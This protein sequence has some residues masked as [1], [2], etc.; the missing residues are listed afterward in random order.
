LPGTNGSGRLI[1]AALAKAGIASL[2]YD[3]RASGPHARENMTA[4]VGKVSMQSHLDEL[5]GAIR[6]LAGRTD[7]RQ[8]CLF[9]LGNSEGTLHILNY[10]LQDPI[11]PLAGLILTGAPGRSVG[12]V[13]HSQLAAQ[14]ANTPNGDKQMALY[15]AAIARFLAGDPVAPDPTLPEGFKML[16]A[17]LEA[18]INLPFAREL[19]AADATIVKQI[20]RPVLIVIGKKDIQIDWQIDGDALRQAAAGRDNV[21]FFFP[22]NANHVLKHETR[23]RQELTGAEIAKSYNAPEAV[24]DI[25][26]MEKIAGWL[27][28]RA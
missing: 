11:I 19:W 13:A 20:D 28:A 23:S 22:D 21:E 2:R 6:V 1:A 26:S 5:A 25:E 16:L 3:K 27:A 8:D 10:Q 17:S 4:L 9:G 7:V 15:D 14:V 24:L 12:A 18:P